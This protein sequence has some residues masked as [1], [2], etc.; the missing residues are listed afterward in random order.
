MQWRSSSSNIP[1]LP[2][3]LV[4]PVSLFTQVISELHKYLLPGSFDIFPYQQTWA[5][6]KNWWTE[7]F[8]KSNQPLGRRIIVTVA[9]V[10]PLNVILSFRHG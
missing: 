5:K 3:V 2:T 6:R 8:G 7:V 10:R 9:S 4:V 1:N